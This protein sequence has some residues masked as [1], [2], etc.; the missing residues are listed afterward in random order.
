MGKILDFDLYYKVNCETVDMYFLEN[1]MFREM[2]RNGYIIEVNV[3]IDR[4]QLVSKWLDT[5][6]WKYLRRWGDRSEFTHVPWKIKLNFC[7][8]SMQ[9]VEEAAGNSL[10]AHVDRYSV[11]IRNIIF[12]YFENARFLNGIIIDVKDIYDHG[13]IKSSYFMAKRLRN[14][15]LHG[16]LN[17]AR[18]EIT[19]AATYEMLKNWKTKDLLSNTMI[20]LDWTSELFTYDV[21]FDI[22]REVF[23][24]DQEVIGW[25]YT[26]EI[27]NSKVKV[28][29]DA[30]LFLVEVEENTEEIT[31]ESEEE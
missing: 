7:F 16:L 3:V 22:A 14:D 24:D 20:Y 1:E 11:T 21:A 13:Y 15:L 23:T 6:H 19:I 31:T 26:R 30:A 12:N 17:G 25:Q 5:D 27:G 29:V 2:K 8:N 4:E 18:L 9:Y 10:I 28:F